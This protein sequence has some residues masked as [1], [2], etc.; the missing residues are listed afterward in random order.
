MDIPAP[1]PE[2]AGGALPPRFEERAQTFLGHPWLPLVAGW[3]VLLGLALRADALV[4]L[5]V[6]L[7]FAGAFLSG[8]VGIGGAIVMIPLL[9]Y[10]PAFA[11]LTAL[12]IKAVAGITMVQVTAAALAGLIGHRR[13]IDRGLFLALG[14]AMVVASFAG[15]VASKAVDARLLEAVFAV[16]ATI[17]AVIML[18]LRRQTVPEVDG[19]VPFRRLVA[20]L[21]GIVVGFGAG[22]IGAGGAFFL[23]PVML[24]GLRI[25]VR[26]TVGTSLA[27]VA[28]SAVAG[29]AGKVITGQVD[30]VLA[31]SLVAGALPGARLGAYVSQRTH[32][33]RLVM[34]LAIAIAAVAVRMWLDLLGT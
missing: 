2:P 32:P 14:P 9:L 27:V 4:G 29:L 15:A 33:D 22:L 34:V 21:V 13:R 8:L 6:G 11:G 10:V 20:V 31:M 1:G 3:L 12:D 28:A 23:I 17:S 7:A 16:M 19:A 5:L 18:G 26:V 25:P 30:W 24:Y